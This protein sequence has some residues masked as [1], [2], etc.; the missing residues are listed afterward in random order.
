MALRQMLRDWVAEYLQA[1]EEIQAIFLV[2]RRRMTYNDRAMVATDRRL[3][4][5]TVNFF[6]RPTG[7]L[8]EAERSIELGPC[9]GSLLYRLPVFG[10]DLDVSRRFFKDVAE[11][12]RAAGFD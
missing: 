10:S 1:G 12:D 4:L 9:R 7:V 11:A 3:L 2:K 5:L 8:A 6:G